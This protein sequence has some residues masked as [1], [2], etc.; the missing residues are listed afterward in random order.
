[1]Y[2]K[3]KLRRV[4]VWAIVRPFAIAR[5][6]RRKGQNMTEIQID[7]TVNTS[8][9]E[10]A[11][12]GNSEGVGY[13][14]Y[15]SP[16]KLEHQLMEVSKQCSV[17]MQL[18]AETCT[19]ALMELDDAQIEAIATKVGLGADIFTKLAEIGASDKIAEHREI[20]PP[21]I[22]ALHA[23][24]NLKDDR[25]QQ[26]LNQG[27]I[28]RDLQVSQVLKWEASVHEATCPKKDD[29]TE[30][31]VKVKMTLHE[32]AAITGLLNY[33]PGAFTHLRIERVN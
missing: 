5:T 8:N 30:F 2:R 13:S 32:A 22:S 25:F 28:K 33:I 21:D 14:G 12:P 17:A 9:P 1:M 7:S 19:I 27:I 11:S 4:F 26:A 31:M 24:A 18:L 3:E 20:L 6:Q 23:L 15:V 16:L 29:G 10:G